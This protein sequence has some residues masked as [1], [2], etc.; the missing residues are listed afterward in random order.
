MLS[1]SRVQVGH[2][3]QVQTRDTQTLGREKWRGRE[4]SRGR[5]RVEMTVGPGSSLFDPAVSLRGD[6]IMGQNL[7][8]HLYSGSC[9][10]HSATL[11]AREAGAPL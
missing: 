4:D 6:Y 7:T 5:G 2:L 3:N 1:L 8:P 10:L 11:K 9:H